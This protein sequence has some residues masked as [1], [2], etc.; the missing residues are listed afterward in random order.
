LGWYS[1]PDGAANESAV[2]LIVSYAPAV[3]DAERSASVGFG[4]TASAATVVGEAATAAEAASSA[5]AR[6][7]PPEADTLDVS[8]GRALLGE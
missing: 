3:A 6:A 5:S 7:V 2:W 8:T 1:R 4:R